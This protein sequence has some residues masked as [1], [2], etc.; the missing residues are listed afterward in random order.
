MAATAQ[1]E[2]SV[3]EFLAWSAGRGLRFE[4]HDGQPVSMSP[5]RV[6]HTVTKG[7]AYFALRRAIERAGAPCRALTEGATV[8]V[9]A[10]TAYVPDALVHC[11]PPPPPAAV[12]I[13]DPLIVV[14]VLSPSTAVIDHGAKL[15]GYFSVPGLEHYLILDADDRML[16]HHKR[17][18]GALIETRIYA[19]GV[20]RLDPPGIELAVAEMF[21]PP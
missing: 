5:E 7:A 12:E 15:R 17:G 16:I 3:D 6:T 19:D 21:A 10:R 4:L 1:K 11:G 9:D 18:Q 2:L 20:L 8:R 14:E 13:S